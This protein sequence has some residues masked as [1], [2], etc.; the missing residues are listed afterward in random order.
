MAGTGQLLTSFSQRVAE[1]GYE[2]VSVSDDG[3][4]IAFISNGDLSGQN[5]D[6]SYEVFVMRADGTQLTQLSN[7]P[8]V[9]GGSV[10][11]V[12]MAGGASKVAFFANTN[13]LGGN[14]NHIR[15]ST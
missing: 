10:I 2:S 5:H 9:N 8:A 6:R 13:P 4:W 3:Q 11:A 14:P 15:R 1:T 7:D 12:A